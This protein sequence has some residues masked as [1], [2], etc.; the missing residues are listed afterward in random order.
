ML[1]RAMRKFAKPGLRMHFV[2][3]IDPADLEAA[4]AGLTPATTFFIVASKTFT[5]VETLDNA[6]RARAWLEAALG[7]STGLSRHFA[8]VTANPAGAE[9]PGVAAEPVVPV[10]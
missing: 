2:S 1:V 3:N 4:L 7:K 5:T 10:G 9:A 6:A 8:A